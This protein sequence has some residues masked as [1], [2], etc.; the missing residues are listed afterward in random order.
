[1]DTTPLAC[2]LQFPL[3]LLFEL[4]HV[5]MH[6]PNWL[7]SLKDHN[8]APLHEQAQILTLHH[9][10]ISILH[11]HDHEQFRVHQNHHEH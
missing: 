11:D 10:F 3:V 8:Y 7:E 6:L 9:L 5:G 2:V 4:Q 1:M